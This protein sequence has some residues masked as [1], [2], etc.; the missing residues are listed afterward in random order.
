MLSV[1]RR[2]KQ[3]NKKKETYSHF[4]SS[5]EWFFGRLGTPVYLKVTVIL[6]AALPLKCVLYRFN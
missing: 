6:T 3:V 5:V 1:R 2:E 4:D